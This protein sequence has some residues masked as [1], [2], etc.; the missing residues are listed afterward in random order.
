MGSLVRSNWR[1]AG[2]GKPRRHE[3]RLGID[4]GG[5]GDAALEHG[6]PL[7]DG[8]AGPDPERVAGF[9]RTEY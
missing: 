1:R 5:Q 4:V 7:R 3:S 2:F 8:L 9:R 6:D